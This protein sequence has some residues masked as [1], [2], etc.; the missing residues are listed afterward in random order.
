METGLIL[1]FQRESRIGEEAVPLRN[2]AYERLLDAII[3]GELKPGSSADEKFLAEHLGIGV[4]AVRDALYRL[5]LE[6]IVERQPR[7]GTRITDLGLREMQDVFEARVLI[8]GGCASLAAERADADDIAAM[9]AALD[10]FEGVI[11]RREFR[12]LVGMDQR[13]HRALAA[14]TKN[15]QIEQK[16][17]QLHDAAC[18]FWYFGLHRME[19]RVILAD[20]AA[21]LDVVTAIE[22]RDAAA[23][24]SAMRAV[25]GHFPDTV[26][27]FFSTANV[28]V[29]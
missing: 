4:T 22:R 11:E 26:R 1:K 3:F 7:I 28:P 15:R 5:S 13:F 17:V 10:G 16:V 20:I 18:R 14:A 6:G 21:H 24:G 27:L 2:T 9:K 19:M 8:E 25:L 12:V 23:A 29:V